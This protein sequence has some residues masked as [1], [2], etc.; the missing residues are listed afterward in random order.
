[1]CQPCFPSCVSLLVSGATVWLYPRQVSG[2]PCATSQISLWPP[3]Q[4]CLL[5]KLL[6]KLKPLFNDLT[7][8]L[9]LCHKESSEP[10]KVFWAPQVHQHSRCE[11][12]DRRSRMLEFLFP[13]VL[14][15]VGAS[16]RCL[17]FLLLLREPTG[18]ELCRHSF[19]LKS[20]TIRWFL[21]TS[22]SPPVHLFPQL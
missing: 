20:F 8:C 7:L 15:L 6:T 22:L 9:W 12:R 14:H 10:R 21:D 5:G 19:G 3:A 16:L 18:Y 13:G 2:M 11:K 1:M 17:T 4:N